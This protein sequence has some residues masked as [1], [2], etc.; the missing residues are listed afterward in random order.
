MTATEI[1]CRALLFDCD[2]VLVDSRITA[3]RAWT[4]WALAL[5]LDPKSVL[6]GL[7]G[8]RSQ[9]TVD[10]HVPKR[11]RRAALDLIEETE[12][13]TAQWTRPIPGG[14]EL[15]NSARHHSAVVTS[16]SLQLASE[17]L[18]AAG[19]PSPS[20]LI[21]GADV[22]LGK[23][24][25]EGYLRAAAKLGVPIGECVIFEDSPAGVEAARAAAP[26]LV[27][28]VGPTV[29]PQSGELV[30]DDLRPVGWTKNGLTHTTTRSTTT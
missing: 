20:V 2:G 17:R 19:Y 3:E 24:A 23:P 9:D 10:L 18:K 28:I 6:E 14:V 4:S 21:S 27:V 7:H 29:Q 11:G 26:G 30:V 5:G 16:A 13:A 22:R 12:L 15:F 8:R 1:A 25:P